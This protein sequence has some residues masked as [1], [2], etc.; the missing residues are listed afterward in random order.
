MRGVFQSF[1]NLAKKNVIVTANKDQ[2]SSNPHVLV[3]SNS[4]S[5]W[6]V[7]GNVNT[8]IEISFVGF[9][10]FVT[11][12]TLKSGNENIPISWKI[13]GEY[14]GEWLEIDEETNSSKL[15]PSFTS[16]VFPAKRG[17][18]SKIKITQTE[19]NNAGFSTFCLSR[20]DFFG[21]L[22]SSEGKIFS[23]PITGI[24][25]VTCRHQRKNVNSLFFFH[26]FGI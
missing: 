14:R 2:Y 7:P 23:C 16:S 22:V 17:Y 8:E 18:Y 21:S 4:N 12:Y 10:I 1:K 3:E 25:M 19:N 6:Y 20:I 26:S 13:T 11:N 9:E 15:I 5:F 24:K